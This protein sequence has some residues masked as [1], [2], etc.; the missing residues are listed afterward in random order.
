MVLKALV[1]M[2]DALIFNKLVQGNIKNTSL[3]DRVEVMIKSGKIMG[4]THRNECL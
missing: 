3:S 4:F 1:E 2:S